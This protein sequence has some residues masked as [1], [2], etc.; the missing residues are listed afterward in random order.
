DPNSAACGDSG[1]P[2]T[3][4]TGGETNQGG[5]TG[6][7]VAI[8]PSPPTD[9]QKCGN[10]PG[11]GY[12]YHDNLPYQRNGVPA[13]VANVN[14]VVVSQGFPYNAGGQLMVNDTLIGWFYQDQWGYYY[15]QAN[16][17]LSWSPSV[18]VSY[19]NSTGFGVSFGLNAA[20]NTTAQQLQQNGSPVKGI[21]SLPA[22]KTAVQ[23]WSSLKQMTH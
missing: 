10:N 14:E 3:G 21:P 4:G 13:Q 12:G 2:E 17:N 7:Q 16:P 15:F 6:D 9:G 19:A 1:S 23:C 20:P 5:S 8:Y 11:S 18:S 22:G